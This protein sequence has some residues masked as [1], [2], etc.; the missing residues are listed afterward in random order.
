MT[1]NLKTEGISV[2]SAVV[3]SFLVLLTRNTVAT[4]VVNLKWF[5]Q[6]RLVRLVANFLHRKDRGKNIVISVVGPNKS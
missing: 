4:D 2:S 3:F 1:E 5:I 6:K